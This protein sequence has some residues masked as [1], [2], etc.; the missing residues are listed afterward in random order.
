MC[1]NFFQQMQQ[2]QPGSG[3]PPGMHGGGAGGFPGMLPTSLAAGVAGLPPTSIA[4]A[5]GLLGFPPGSAGAN[6][7]SNAAGQLQ[8]QQQH[9]HSQLGGLMNSVTSAASREERDRLVSFLKIKSTCLNLH[10]LNILNAILSC[11]KV[12]IL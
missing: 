9:Q 10:E 5:A 6:A 7:L 2:M 1:F 8:Q 12:N 3:L 4:A 11:L